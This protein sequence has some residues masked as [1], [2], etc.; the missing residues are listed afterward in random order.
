MLIK[1]K[2]LVYK[3]I[4]NK[5]KTNN[6]KYEKNIKNKLFSNNN[7]E[8]TVL[9]YGFSNP[10]IANKTIEDL[11]NRDIDY[12]FQVVN[13][14]YNRGLQVI[15]K[16]K[17]ILSISNIKKALYIFSDWL[18]KYKSNKLHSKLSKPYLTPDEILKLE[19]LA[20]Y[21]NISRKARG[22]EKPTTSDE[23][24]LVVWR[25]VKGD[26]KKLRNYPVKKY[27]PQGQTWDKQ[28]NNFITRRLSMIKNAKDKL[29]YTSGN[30][31]GLPTK[32]HINM[33]MWGYSPDVK[34][35]LSGINKYKE[36][37]KHKH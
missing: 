15:K 36:I 13:T 21:Y 16:T 22:L 30:N 20:E 5:T 7:P 25:R 9:G 33:V 2:K 4:K 11:K 32:L 28:R 17:N 26:K 6:F 12:Q 3:T 35:L 27:V 10:R 18:K 23:G 37:I 24:F 34:N 14:M 1:T 8:T 19:F 31:K 29:Y